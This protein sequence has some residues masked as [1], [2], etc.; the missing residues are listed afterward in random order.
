MIDS[1]KLA[2]FL[3]NQLAPRG[4]FYRESPEFNRSYERL[5]DSVIKY[6]DQQSATLLST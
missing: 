5:A 3:R 2:V 1:T 6:I 4:N